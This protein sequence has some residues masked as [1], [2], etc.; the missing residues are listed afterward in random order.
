MTARIS[1]IRKEDVLRVA[2]QYIDMEHL[3]IDDR[4]RSREYRRV[5]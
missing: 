3:A 5:A 1:E 4:R 2:K